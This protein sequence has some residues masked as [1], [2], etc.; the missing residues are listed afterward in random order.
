MR[1]K[2][3]KH[4][5]ANFL[6]KSGELLEQGYNLDQVLEL[7]SWEQTA[8]I[9]QII[10]DMR[11]QLRIGSPFHEVLAQRTFPSDITAYV[12]FSE[13][14]GSLSQGLQGAG[15]LYL[16]RLNAL[17]NIRRFMRYPLVLLWLLI[18]I[19]IVMVHFL[20]PQFSQLFDSLHME[21]PLLTLTMLHI[22]QY[23][24]Y[25]FLFI[26]PTLLLCFLYYIKVFRHYS[27]HKQVKILTRAPFLESFIRLFL[28]YYFCLQFSSMLKGGLSIYEACLV[29]EKQHHFAF[30]Q[31]EG[32]F[33][34]QQLKEGHQLHA[35]LEAAGWYRDEMKYVIQHGQASGKLGDDLFFYSE[36]VFQLLEE[37]VKKIVM[38][39]QP[40]MF[41][42]IGIVILGMFLSVFL[43]MFQLMTSI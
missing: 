42:F 30:F 27:A 9:K 11:E 38:A 20:F 2:W 6:L 12:F 1:K 21:F 19:S 37:K 35:A 24:P 7:L 17:T 10:Y 43:P 15:E 4:A 5:A 3:S 22:F 40:V 39:V 18:L 26:F 13:Q 41:C 32:K 8:E 16:K 25:M 36:K 14:C 29:F 23:A 34:K 31:T 28:T 33:L